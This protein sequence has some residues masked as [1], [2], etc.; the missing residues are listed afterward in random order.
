MKNKTKQNGIPLT[1]LKDFCLSVKKYIYI[2]HGKFTVGANHYLH[3]H[4][5]KLFIE[6][7]LLKVGNLFKYELT[8]I[9][10]AEIIDSKWLQ[11]Y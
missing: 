10:W 5:T 7:K 2:S 8:Y 3:V 1:L 9:Y 6:N 4:F 11:R